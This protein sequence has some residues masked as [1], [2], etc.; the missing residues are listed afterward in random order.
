MN[1][2][3]IYTRFPSTVAALLKT[4]GLVDSLPSLPYVG[5]TEDLEMVY[6][7]DA[8]SQALAFWFSLALGCGLI[9]YYKLVT[10]WMVKQESARMHETESVE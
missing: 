9:D 10:P 8:I 7:D 1:K 5:A 4:H 3:I 6:P 2:L